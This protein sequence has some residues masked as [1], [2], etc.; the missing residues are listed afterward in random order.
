MAHYGATAEKEVMTTKK[1]TKPLTEKEWRLRAGRQ[2]RRIRELE[3]SVET[4]IVDRRT[5]RNELT[6]EF[7]KEAREVAQ[8]IDNA[9]LLLAPVVTPYRQMAS[10]PPPQEPAG[11]VLIGLARKLW[12]DVHVL[13]TL[14]RQLASARDQAERNLNGLRRSHKEKGIQ[15]RVM[16]DVYD[17]AEK[18]L[19]ELELGRVEVAQYVDGPNPSPPPAPE[20]PHAVP[21]KAPPPAGSYRDMT[22]KNAPRSVEE[23][24]ALPLTVRYR[25]ALETGYIQDAMHDAGFLQSTVKQQAEF[26]LDAMRKPARVQDGEP[27]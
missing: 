27:R 23:L 5:L 26:L 9:N 13:V 22:I 20:L 19:Q 17:A 21:P 2:E 4:A 12:S 15:L 14:H 25:L 3:R 24:A 6:N 10:M 1:A 7:A 8:H 11:S 18:R 16:T